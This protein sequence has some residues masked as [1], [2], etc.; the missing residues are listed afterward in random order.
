[1]SLIFG[2]QDNVEFPDPRRNRSKNDQLVPPFST[3]KKS[4]AADRLLQI[5]AVS[6]PVRFRAKRHHH[7]VAQRRVKRNPTANRKK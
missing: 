5:A 2:Q 1:M 3:S 6:P 7:M 4:L